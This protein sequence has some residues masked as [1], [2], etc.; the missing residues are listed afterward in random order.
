MHFLF[1]EYKI[2]EINIDFAGAVKNPLYPKDMCSLLSLWIDNMNLLSFL[3][4]G[5]RSIIVDGVLVHAIDSAEG[6]KLALLPY[7]DIRELSKKISTLEKQIS[8][9]SKIVSYL[10]S[11]IVGLTVLGAALSLRAETKESSYV[12]SVVN[13]LNPILAAVCGYY[14]SESKKDG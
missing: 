10:F 1:K 6:F 2:I 4:V 8:I 5:A 14:F 13:G 11:S 3:A 12:F 7:Q 9:K